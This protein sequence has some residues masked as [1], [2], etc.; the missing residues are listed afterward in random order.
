MTAEVEVHHV[1]EE[2]NHSSNDEVKEQSEVF[3]KN[4]YKAPTIKF[5]GKS[6]YQ[7]SYFKKPVS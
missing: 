2:T 6:T 4:A 3:G 5:N 7:A 1:Y